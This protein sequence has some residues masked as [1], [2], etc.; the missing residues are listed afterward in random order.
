MSK[1][2]KD[3]IWYYKSYG[4]FKVSIKIF[5]YI[6]FGILNILTEKLPRKIYSLFN[7]CYHFP[8]LLRQKLNL[9]FLK[10]HPRLLH[11][12]C[13][14]AHTIRRLRKP[15]SLIQ[16][17]KIKVLHI[18]C[19]FDLGGTQKQI[20]QVCESVD[21][22]DGLIHET[23]E[24]FP[25]LNFL[26]RESESLDSTRY[27]CGNP[28]SRKLG[29]LTLCS[30][31][32]SL[33]VVQ[34]Y[35]LVRDFKAIQPDVVVGWGHEIAMLTFV[36][37]AIVRVPKIV[38]CIRTFNP[39]YGWTAIGPLLEKAHKRMEPFLD[40]IIVNSSILREDYSKWLG[41][42]RGRVHV[43]PN[44]ID[45]EL[46]RGDE[47]LRLRQEIR[48]RWGIGNDAVAI[49]HVGR[50]SGEKGQMLLLRAN[51]DLQTIYG[52]NT[53]HWFLCGDGPTFEKAEDYRNRHMMD[54]VSFTGRINDVTPFLCAADIFVM[55]SDFEGM[56][57]AMMEAMAYGLPCISTNRTGA[58]DIARD[59]LEALYVDVGS[60]EQLGEK[61]NYLIARPDERKRLGQN[62]RERIKEFSVDNM[63]RLF[64]KHLEEMIRG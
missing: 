62:A 16:T 49:L 13:T 34:I 23:I 41:I 38:F 44:G 50:F 10:Y 56:P 52:S 24:I 59:N 18:T 53:V 37:A 58:L 46:P 25:E 21:N 33:Q 4:F 3:T 36:A 31:S 17:D 5:K 42:P 61:L 30:S 39:S 27:T 14:N 64:D 29:T 60:V 63:V 35:K 47:R 55:P 57:N 26:Y 28:I 51:K 22:K 48:S 8:S 1:L 2:I 43:C 40:G 20:L 11:I 7:I 15:R 32:R 45:G 54:N 19:S 6:F 9:I 12:T